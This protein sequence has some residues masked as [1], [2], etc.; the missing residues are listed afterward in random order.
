VLESG[1]V[2]DVT[3]TE[4]LD[5][6]YGLDDAA[7]TAAKQWRFEPA[8]KDGKPVTVAVDVEMTFTLK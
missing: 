6:V 4:S 8:T 3:V 7:V 2:G 5:P 1:G